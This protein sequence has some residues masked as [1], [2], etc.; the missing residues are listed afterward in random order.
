MIENLKELKS[1]TKE[2]P[3]SKFYLISQMVGVAEAYKY[4]NE[5]YEHLYA[6]TGGDIW[7]TRFI[8]AYNYYEEIVHDLIAEYRGFF[9]EDEEI[10]IF[11]DIIC[12]I[13]ESNNYFKAAE[14]RLE[15]LLGPVLEDL[16]PEDN[17]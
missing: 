10:E 3:I 15:Y 13:S 8:D 7:E 6:I 1:Q 2:I 4:W 16:H 11:K 17:P 5:I 14:E 9:I 12:E